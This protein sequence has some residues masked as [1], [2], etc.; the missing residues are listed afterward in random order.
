MLDSEKQL[1]NNG[2]ILLLLLF[3]SF[4]YISL[5]QNTW[6]LGEGRALLLHSLI[7]PFSICPPSPWIRQAQIHQGGEERWADSFH[8]PAMGRGGWVF[9]M[10]PDASTQCSGSQDMGHQA[11]TVP[12]VHTQNPSDS[13][14]ENR[15]TLKGWSW[16]MLILSWESTK[17]VTKPSGDGVFPT[18][19]GLIAHWTP[20]TTQLPALELLESMLWDAQPSRDC[21]PQRRFC[22]ALHCHCHQEPIGFGASPGDSW[23]ASHT[24]S[25]SHTYSL[26]YQFKMEMDGE[27][28][29]DLKGLS[30]L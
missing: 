1:W 24:G 5:T 28:P 4:T 17:E 9:C 26:V 30:Q 8:V 10:P 13:W 3:W 12:V 29:D 21:S 15:I 25:E 20:I 11:S 14:R 19:T 23:G 7:S 27:W 16:K 6:I 18:A 22:P 2:W